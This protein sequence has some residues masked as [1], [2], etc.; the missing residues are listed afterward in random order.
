[1]KFGDFNVAD[2]NIN[3]ALMYTID[4]YIYIGDLKTNLFYI[5][6]NMLDDFDLPQQI[7]KDLVSVWGAL[8]HER[9]Q[10]RYFASIEDMLS[11][12]YDTHNEEY[13]IR[14]RSGQYVW[15]HCRGVLYRDPQTNEP[16]S[17]IGVVKKPGSMGK[18]DSV[19]GLLTHESCRDAMNALLEDGAYDQAGL[20]VLGID[21]FARINTLKSHH[22]GDIVLRNVAQDLLRMLPEGAQIYR[23]DG[24]QFAILFTHGNRDKMKALYQ[25]IQLY[26]EASHEIDDQKYS[27][28]ISGGAVC[29]TDLEVVKESPEKCASIALREAKSQ[30]KNQCVFF[31]ERM[32]DYQIRGQRILQEMNESIHDG[33][34][35]FSLVYQP[36]ADMKTMYVIGAEALLRYESDA[37]GPIGPDEFIPLLEHSG[38]ILQVGKW[39]LSE[40]L[41]TCACW[42]KD[43]PDFVMNVN[44]SCLQFKDFRFPF[45]VK[46]EL[47]R[48]HLPSECLTIE[49]TETYF[50]TDSEEIESTVSYLHRLGGNIAMDDFGT[51]YSSLGRLSEFNIDIVKI[52]RLF[53]KSLNVNHYNHKFIEAV[54]RLCHS[55]G[56]H[57]C[58]EGVETS[59]EYQSIS[60][61]NA[62]TIQGYYLSRPVP[63][64]VFNERFIQNKDSLQELR[65]LE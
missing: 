39:V 35:G 3:D 55:A 29:F 52:D 42:R 5:S 32:L 36:I 34:R 10:N 51:G 41:R 6:K 44:A 33:F 12:K 57:V 24:D 21:D 11:G 49:M 58:I 8:I 1:M 19:T 62:D 65:R 61:L 47:E 45:D 64:K 15:V 18:I 7:V 16:M 38:L 53:V 59:E 9:D 22:F 43:I 54:V 27:F 40:A 26:G 50:V 28:T 25:K 63:Q 17:F 23:F 13:Q 4:D 14:N 30:G 37:F 56:M 60:G 2:Q 46:S 20:M 31:E 48:Y